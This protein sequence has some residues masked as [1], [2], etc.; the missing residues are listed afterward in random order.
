M[1]KAL[2]LLLTIL[3]I[4]SLSSAAFA[5]ESDSS[6]GSGFVETHGQAITVATGGTVQSGES[7]EPEVSEPEISEPESSEPEVSEPENSVS[8]QGQSE[9]STGESSLSEPE[10]SVSSQDE[11]SQSSSEDESSAS[12]PESSGDP[13]KD[14]SDTENP[15]NNDDEIE[16]L[17]YVPENRADVFSMRAMAFRVPEIQQEVTQA[18]TTD[19]IIGVATGGT[20]MSAWIPV[21][22]IPDIE[23]ATISPS[24]R[25]VFAIPNDNFYRNSGSQTAFDVNLTKLKTDPLFTSKVEVMDSKGIRTDLFDVQFVSVAAKGTGQAYGVQLTPKGITSDVTLYSDITFGFSGQ[26]NKYKLT[27]DLL[28]VPSSTGKTKA[29]GIMSGAE[30]G[31]DY[32]WVTKNDRTEDVDF[33]DM[34]DVMAG[35]EYLIHFSPQ[36]FEWDGNIPAKVTLTNIRGKISLRQTGTASSRVFDVVELASYKGE[37]VVRIKFRENLLSTKPIDFKTKLYLNVKGKRHD[38]SGLELSGTFGDMEP[39][40]YYSEDREI[41]ISDGLI[42]IAKENMNQV[43]VYIGDGVTL[44]VPHIRKNAKFYG[45][46][47]MN[48][49]KY[50]EEMIEKYPDIVEVYKLYT[51]GLNGAGVKVDIDTYNGFHIYDKDLNY[52]GQSTRKLDYSETYY[53]AASMLDLEEEEDEIE[54]EED[55]FYTDDIDDVPPSQNPNKNPGTGVQARSAG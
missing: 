5:D 22:G 25:L 51:L 11:Q 37:A 12:E 24:T 52:L 49:D 35:D 4:V 26:N 20:T 10:S 38:D 45:T 9:A 44:T 13:D 23:G 36:F 46:V 54:D 27:K 15:V 34:H 43:K 18:G 42:C 32:T 14:N 1:K 16:D 21:S 2:A 29:I 47:S 6:G 8:P 3:L 33:D 17:P 30:L 31:G 53:L 55:E 48:F 7:S 28:I 50:D 41:D 40:E 39:E 19:K